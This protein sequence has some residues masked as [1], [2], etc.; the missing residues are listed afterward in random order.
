M[1]R[2]FAILFIFLAGA[3]L[4]AHSVVPHQ[5]HDEMLLAITNI[6]DN[7]DGCDESPCD[8][9][10]CGDCELAGSAVGAYRIEKDRTYNPVP[11]NA[12]LDLP[13]FLCCTTC[14]DA[15]IKACNAGSPRIYPALKGLLPLYNSV[16]SKGLRA[17][18]VF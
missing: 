15:S 18:P 17:P 13:L 8:H 16:E 5:H 6:F 7:G 14:F 12:A 2:C 3:T 9:S 10:D 1:R 11:D 4:L